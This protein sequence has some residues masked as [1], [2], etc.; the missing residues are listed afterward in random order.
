MVTRIVLRNIGLGVLGLI[1]ATL[2]VKA[3]FYMSVGVDR[4][5]HTTH[6]EIGTDYKAIFADKNSIQL[7]TASS[8]GVAPQDDEANIQQ[9]ISE[10]RLV[11]LHSCRYYVST[12]SMPYLTPEAAD[13]LAEIGR[14]YKM[15][16]GYKLKCP[17]ATS[18]FRTREFVRRLQ[19]SNGNAVANS[20]HLY[21]TTFDISYSRMSKNEKRVMAQVLADLREAGYCHVLYEVN[22]PCFHITVRK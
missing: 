15:E 4:E 8:M 19:K 2:A 7:P 13:L 9:L 12:A 22:Q 3:Y 18:M 10:G 21:G 6:V 11:K 14:R 20:C 17:I 5:Y 16:L 1:V